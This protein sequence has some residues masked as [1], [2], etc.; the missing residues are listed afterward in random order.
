MSTDKLKSSKSFRVALEGKSTEALKSEG[1][2]VL[3]KRCFCVSV[4]P[5]GDILKKEANSPADFR[6]ICARS[7]LAWVDYW[8]DDFEKNA[9]SAATQLGFSEV[10]LSNLIGDYAVTYQD[11]NIEMGVRLPSVHVVGFEVNSYPLLM[12]LRK[13]FIL[14]I[15]PLS[16]DRRFARL[17]RYS[18]T[19][20]KKIPS[21]IPPEDKLTHLLIR[22]IDENNDRNFEELRRIEEQGDELSQNLIDPKMPRDKLGIEIHHMKHALITYL[23]AL[24][25]TV[26]V[27][28]ALR[29][30]DA[31]LITNDANILN[32]MVVLSDDVS[33]QIELGEHMSEVLASGLEVLQSIYNNQLQA[34]NNRLALVMTYLTIL[35]TAVLV[36]NTLATIFSNSAFN[37]G[38]QDVGWYVALLVGSTIAATALA[39]WWVKKRGWLPKKVD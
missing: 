19:I 26:D 13:N 23:N 32:K 30:G 15:H 37:L 14:T 25:S 3:P 24:W 7:P 5:S 9:L 2:G 27:I 31:D 36:P 12:L 10:L 34:L 20:L 35:G 21:N 1:M 16:P 11:F 28:H 6:E 4:S 17:R 8:T 33:R 22:I 38:P 29:Y 18:D 39:Y